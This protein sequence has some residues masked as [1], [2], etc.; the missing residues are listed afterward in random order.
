MKRSGS[1]ASK[2]QERTLMN[3]K[4]RVEDTLPDRLYASLA[5]H[6]QIKSSTLNIELQFT[7]I[8]ISKYKVHD[9]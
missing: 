1:S 4:V 9:K 3:Y 6:V 5:F 2:G 8:S 7:G